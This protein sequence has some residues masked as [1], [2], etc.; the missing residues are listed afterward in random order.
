[1]KSLFAAPRYAPHGTKRRSLATQHIGSN[2]S[3]ADIGHRARRSSQA[4]M[5]D[6]VEKG[7]AIFGE[8]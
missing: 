6:T 3:E 4:L 7:L 8:Q 1:V 2:Q 5:T